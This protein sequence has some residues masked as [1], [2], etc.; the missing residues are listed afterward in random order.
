MAR[1]VDIPLVYEVVGI[2]RGKRNEQ[3]VNVLDFVPVE[4]PE[5]SSDDLPVALRL[6][7]EKEGVV[8]AHDG[9]FLFSGS[10]S[11]QDLSEFSS[12]IDVARMQQADFGNFTTQGVTP[13][14]RWHFGT[15]LHY[16]GLDALHSQI[17]RSMRT[18]A[19]SKEEDARQALHRDIVPSLLIVDGI[20]RVKQGEPCWTVGNYAP[21]PGVPEKDVN[22]FFLETSD[23][24]GRV[25]G[26]RMD[27]LEQAL[28][29]AGRF[30]RS[31][32]PPDTTVEDTGAVEWGLDESRIADATTREWLQECLTDK[33]MGMLMRDSSPEFFAAYCTL[34]DHQ[35]HSRVE[36]ADA[37][38]A[39]R[40][41]IVPMVGA[42][43]G[44]D[45]LVRALDMHMAVEGMQEP[46]SDL[47]ALGSL[48]I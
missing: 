46:S 43:Y 17:D 2:P 48:R 25:W 39:V 9:G 10:A 21:L 38:R 11:R 47:S 28:E 31:V 22:V 3:K 37:C 20:L 44:M 14:L 4:I 8:L 35:L 6:H 12:A 19:S 40:E 7:G 5:A 15:S 36:I 32:L 18:I 16:Q 26:F 27:R 24:I 1:I 41:R 29:L 33:V 23:W 13:Q 34:R 30:G 42:E 45:A